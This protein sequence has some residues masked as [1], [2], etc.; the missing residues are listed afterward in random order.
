V[1]QAAGLSDKV[2]GSTTRSTGDSAVN[3]WFATRLKAAE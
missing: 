1:Q 3:R 2:M